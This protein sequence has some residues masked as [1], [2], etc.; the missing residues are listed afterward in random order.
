[1]VSW[2]QTLGHSYAGTQA[3]ATS[4]PGSRLLHLA[5]LPGRRDSESLAPTTSR[6]PLNAGTVET[7]RQI[8]ELNQNGRYV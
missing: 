5:R 2:T 8:T 1:M 6:Q 3:P 7:P 4:T